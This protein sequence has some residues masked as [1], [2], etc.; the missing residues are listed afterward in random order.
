MKGI[1]F[2]TK[3]HNKQICI[4]EDIQNQLEESS[5]K[6][7]RV[8]VLIEETEDDDDFSEIAAKEFLN[9]YASSD[10]IYDN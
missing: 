2:K 9:G 6:N 7:V 8:I 3:I 4:P 10:S 5:D 1:A